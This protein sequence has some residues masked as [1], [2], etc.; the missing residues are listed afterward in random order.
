MRQRRSWAGLG[1]ALGLACASLFPGGGAVAQSL[2]SGGP[3]SNGVLTVV[4]AN[5]FSATVYSKNG[6]PAL[7]SL[8]RLPDGEYTYQ[9]SAA[10]RQLVGAGTLQNNGRGSASTTLRRGVAGSGTFRVVRGAF[11]MAA[12]PALASSDDRD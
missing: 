10:T 3:H 8:G 5:G 6:V 11:V 12:A 4:G 9:V 1:A 2:L 7:A